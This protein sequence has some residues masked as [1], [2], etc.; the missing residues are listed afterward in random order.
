MR[1][2]GRFGPVHFLIACALFFESTG[3]AINLIE[4]CGSQFTHSPFCGLC[5]DPCRTSRMSQRRGFRLSFAK[6]FFYDQREGEDQNEGRC[7]ELRESCETTG[8]RFAQ[9]RSA[10][11]VVMT[12]RAAQPSRRFRNAGSEWDVR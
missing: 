9:R 8:E 1:K 12:F 6:I 11:A 4:K 2:T 7:G 3:S 5:G 10:I